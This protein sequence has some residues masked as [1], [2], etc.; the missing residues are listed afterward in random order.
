MKYKIFKHG[1]INFT[2]PK[3]KKDKAS[4]NKL[5]DEEERLRRELASLN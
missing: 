1:D 5:L 3:S 4:M 2:A